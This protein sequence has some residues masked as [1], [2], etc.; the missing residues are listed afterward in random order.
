MAA[1]SQR[2]WDLGPFLQ[3]KG[4]GIKKGIWVVEKGRV[5]QKLQSGNF[6]S[7]LGGVSTRRPS[8][9]SFEAGYHPVRTQHWVS[10]VTA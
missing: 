4:G 7:L 5:S 2:A 3:K 9:G 6:C 1:R 10:E 8:S